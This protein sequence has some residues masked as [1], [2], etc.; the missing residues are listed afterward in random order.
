M[1]FIWDALSFLQRSCNSISL[2]K[3]FW[4]AANTSF[5]TLSRTLLTS[6]FNCNF[7]SSVCIATPTMWT[8]T[9][10][11]VSNS[12][13]IQNRDAD[14]R[15]KHQHGVLYK[16]SWTADS[17]LVIPEM[18]QGIA[19]LFSTHLSQ[20]FQ[21]LPKWDQPRQTA[22]HQLTCTADVCHHTPS[23]AAIHKLSP[24]VRPSS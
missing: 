24:C 14:A 2:S 16:H 8:T 7:S 5:W 15:E 19:D 4:V 21:L 22:L 1:V 23:F 20:L 13:A 17:K 6:C 9:V 10:F 18:L 11:Q 12:S 3:C